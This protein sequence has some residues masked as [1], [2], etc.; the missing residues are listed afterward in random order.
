[1]GA[2][3]V[4]Q[5]TRVNSA[6]NEMRD[7]REWLVAPVVALVPGV[8]NQELVLP[9]EIGRYTPA[10][11]DSPVTVY[12]PHDGVSHV[13]ARSIDMLEAFACGRLYDV[14]FEDGRLKGD[15]WLDISRLGTFG[16]AGDAILRQIVEGTGCEVSTGYFRDVEESSGT[17]KG[18]PYLTVAR[19]IRPDHLALL[20]AA[21]GA[22]NWADG[23]G[24]PRTNRVKESSMTKNQDAPAINQTLARRVLSA[25][26]EAFGLATEVR[27]TARSPEY[28]GV[29]DTSWGDVDKSLSAYIA[30]YNEKGGGSE[31]GSRLTDLS[32]ACKTWIASKTLL[33]EASAETTDDLIFF[34]V[35][36]PA[37]DAL[38][39]GALRA[40]LSGRGSQADISE[41]ALESA[42]AKAQSLLDE[43]S[44]ED[45][46]EDTANNDGGGKGVV[47]LFLEAKTA[48]GLAL[49]PGDLPP[50]SIVVEA[51]NLSI[52]L[53]SYEA[54]QA[55]DVTLGYLASELAGIA[56]STSIMVTPVT[57]IGRLMTGGD[58][59]V[60][61]LTIG[62]SAIQRWAYDLAGYLSFW[63]YNPESGDEAPEVEVMPMTLILA[64]IPSDAATPNIALENMVVSFSHIGVTC[65]GS[66]IVFG[67]AGEL[68]PAPASP[69]EDA[70][71]EAQTE[72][73]FITYAELSGMMAIAK[74]ARATE[75]EGATDPITNGDDN[76]NDRRQL[77]E[78]LLANADCHCTRETLEAMSTDDLKVMADDILTE[79]EQNPGEVIAMPGTEATTPENN[80]ADQG[81]PEGDVSETVVETV[82]ETDGELPEAE[83]QVNE[84][85][86][87]APIAS[88]APELPAELAE[89]LQVVRD[90]GGVG[91]LREALSAIQSNAASERSELIA[92]L[93]ANSRCA[94]SAEELATFTTDQL[95]K[96]HQSLE[97][98]DF[99]FKPRPNG[100][101]A[102]GSVVVEIPMP[103]L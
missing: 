20:P 23:C 5:R 95:T 25:L 36:N 31:E 49:T 88:A 48:E 18:K 68:R 87:P 77:I 26:A 98:T 102:P 4:T 100:R 13:S 33:G 39:L 43:N 27:S 78:A 75:S 8:L 10:W 76:M 86:D 21:E 90:F 41:A 81:T 46:T 37:T 16:E 57:G 47:A 30:G 70:E 59:D 7:G 64:Y 61:Y 54:G 22:C 6:R 63:A 101:T 42:R 17:Y 80:E 9:D 3:L 38:N 93:T 62:G 94:F 73:R 32:S 74:N 85:D 58:Y 83:T 15:V 66:Q 79:D 55:A 71:S 34:P 91:P 50:G 53:L 60:L 28:D 103:T 29:E 52:P 51:G 84:D 72:G 2:G 99:S 65:G 40:V 89:L 69:T 14:R 35:V 92:S 67:L 24:V 12:H 44:D 82:V 1:M 96:L 19:N 11:D 56:R 97:P 45:E